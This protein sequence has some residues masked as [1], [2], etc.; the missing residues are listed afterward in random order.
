MQ[1]RN[2]RKQLDEVQS[3]KRVYDHIIESTESAS[4]TVIG[5]PSLLSEVM[6]EMGRRGGMIG[7]KRRLET[8]TDERRR[9]IASEAA[10]ARWKASKRSKKK[11]SK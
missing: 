7:G 4:L 8:L 6:R 5:N 10:K 1:K 3:A 2:S 9:E 11:A